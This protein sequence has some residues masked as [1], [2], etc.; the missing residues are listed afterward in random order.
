LFNNIKNDSF[1]RNDCIEYCK[2]KFGLLED[3]ELNELL[4]LIKNNKDIID[5]K[6]LR[7]I[8]EEE[9]KNERNS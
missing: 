8:I 9:I 6:E 5:I 7:R 4:L 3:E 1:N 2:N